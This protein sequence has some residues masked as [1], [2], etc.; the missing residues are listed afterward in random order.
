MLKKYAVDQEEHSYQKLKEE[1]EEDYQKV[2]NKREKGSL[3]VFQPRG[4]AE[5]W[6]EKIHWL[7]S[8]F[9]GIHIQDLHELDQKDSQLKAE[10]NTSTNESTKKGRGRPKKDKDYKTEL[11]IVVRDYDDEKL[12]ELI[13]SAPLKDKNIL[14]MRSEWF[15][16]LYHMDQWYPREAWHL[17]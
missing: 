3:S 9:G 14:L 16:R 15:W 6:R 7:I 10:D 8:A 13:S 4:T 1:C 17:L 2:K 11:N 5:E 12:V